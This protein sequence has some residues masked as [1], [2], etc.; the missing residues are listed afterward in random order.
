MPAEIHSKTNRASTRSGTKRRF[1]EANTSEEATVSATK[2]PKKTMTNVG[3]AEMNALKD[4]VKKVS[5]CCFEKREA[6]YS[7]ITKKNQ[8]Q[9]CTETKKG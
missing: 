5:A 3:E 8:L 4:H 7:T 1:N 9:T 6:R 2:T